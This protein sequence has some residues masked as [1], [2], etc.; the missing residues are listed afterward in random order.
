MRSCRAYYLVTSTMAVLLLAVAVAGAQTPDIPEISGPITGPDLMYPNPPINVVTDAAQVE[1]FPYITEEYFVSG[2]AND[3]PYTTRIIVRRPQRIGRFSGT[4]VAEAL[5]SGGRSLIFEWSRVSIL[6]RGHIFVEIV[7]SPGNIALLQAFNAQRYASLNISNGQTNEIIAQVGRLIKSDARPFRRYRV[8][9]TTL[10]GTSASSGTVRSYL[11]AHALLRLPDNGPIFDGFLLT[12]TNG[13]TPL[14]IVDVP[15]IQMPTQTEV[16][17][18]AEAGIAYRRPDSDDPGNRFRIFEVAGMPHNNARDIPFFFTDPCTLP[19]TDFPAGAFTA[20]GLNYLI[21]WIA[22]G[23]APPHAPYIEVDQDPSNDG[24][25][26]A[27]DEFGN[28]RGGVRNVW[29]DVPIATYGVF[30]VGKVPTSDRLCLLIGTEVPFAD[31]T[32]SALYRDETQYVRRINRR[33]RELIREGW[34]L[35]EYAESVRED[36]RKTD[37]P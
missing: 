11:S 33:L 34:F 1:D 15:M 24:S 13:N 20:L 25:F 5:H 17:T 4:V 12:S 21:E 31:E 22:D 28:A 30:G 3:L 32:L 26:L 7:H 18:W 9:R 6:T 14:P 37:I 16:V 29:V 23:I 19:I 2:I 36:A 8:Q 10:M 27:L 35:R